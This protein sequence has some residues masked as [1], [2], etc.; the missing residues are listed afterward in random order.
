MWALWSHITRF[1]VPSNPIGS[2]YLVPHHEFELINYL[3]IMRPI[4][5]VFD[6]KFANRKVLLLLGSG[7]SR[8]RGKR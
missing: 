6:F 4:D 1:M 3:F 7:M 2:K 5:P 8:T